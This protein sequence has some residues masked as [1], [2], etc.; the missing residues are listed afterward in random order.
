MGILVQ[1]LSMVLAYVILFEIG[2]ENT[3]ENITFPTIFMGFMTG[4]LI[5]EAKNVFSREYLQEIRLSII[6]FS[7]FLV[8]FLQYL[9]VRLVIFIIFKTIV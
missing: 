1:L 2:L 9:W 7:S 8:L 5:F 4:F 6:I 3:Q